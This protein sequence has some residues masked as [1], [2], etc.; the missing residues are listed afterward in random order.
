MN[1]EAYIEEG[2]LEAYALGLCNE[3][4]TM[5]VERLCLMYP[6]LQDELNKIK[7]G[8]GAYANAHSKPVPTHIKQN[9]FD[10]IDALENEITPITI[11][12][13]N[14][15]FEEEKTISFFNNKWLVAASIAMFILSSITNVVL[16][17]KWKTSNEQMIALN[18]EKNFLS[19]NSKTNQVKMDLMKQEM[20]IIGS[21]EMKKVMMK[22]MEKSP[23]SMAIIYWNR[24]TREVYLEKTKLPKPTTGMQYQ[25]WAIVD[26]KPMDAGILP[27]DDSDTTLIKMKDFGNAQ[28]FAITQE[29][30]GGSSSPNLSEM[31]VMGSI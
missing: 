7:E 21:P 17:S 11:S 15:N 31:L 6:A 16:Y 23:E 5:D 14:D 27:M 9:I 30:M 20:K 4:E 26:G 3:A 18:A 13:K 19:D 24:N 25:L 29:K 1:I 12:Y 2:F 8:L 10:K 22:G 28:A